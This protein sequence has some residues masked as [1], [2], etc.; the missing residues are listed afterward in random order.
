MKSVKK[1]VALILI[2]LFSF[3]YLNV[4][5]QPLTSAA[6]PVTTENSGD[7]VVDNSNGPGFC[8]KVL[9]P[10]KG[11]G[12]EGLSGESVQINKNSFAQFVNASF[13]YVL[14]IV[15]IAAIIYFIFGGLTYLTTDIVQKKSEGKEI[16]TR[17]VTGLIFI[18]SIFAIFKAINPDLLKA[19][20][21]FSK[22]NSSVP[23]TVS[24]TLPGVNTTIENPGGAILGSGGTVDL[25]KKINGNAWRSL[26]TEQKRY[27]QTKMLEVEQETR[28]R[29]FGIFY[30]A[31]C[32]RTCVAFLTDLAIRRLLE[33][34]AACGC[35][36]IITGGTEPW[37]H[38]S[39]GLNISNVDLAIFNDN[40]LDSFIKKLPKKGNLD[41][42][43]EVYYWTND[44][45]FCDEKTSR[46][47]T[48]RHWHVIFK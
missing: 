38:D 37:S 4:L 12:L 39:H 27:V 41:F 43:Y 26:N 5:A 36:I 32:T 35:N 47:S 45:Q 8:Y 40:N 48:G 16:V 25:T 24:N 28:N 17:V 18:F 34:K 9:E 6:N 19:G 30:N 22:A 46:H 31:N 29:L 13:S 33:L 23:A 20:L 1:F 15:S 10:I 3:T 7:C 42:C 2:S 44:T 21:D 14:I 11:T